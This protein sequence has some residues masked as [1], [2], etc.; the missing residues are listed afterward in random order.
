MY[1][2][3]NIGIFAAIV[4]ING[5]TVFLKLKGPKQT[6]E[7]NKDKFLSLIGSIEVKK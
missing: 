6:L 5:Q 7:D 4:P 3:E 2:Q 1:N